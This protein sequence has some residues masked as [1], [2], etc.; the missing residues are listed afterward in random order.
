MF[1]MKEMDIPIRILP[2]MVIT[3]TGYIEKDSFLK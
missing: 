2:I 1:K 3:C